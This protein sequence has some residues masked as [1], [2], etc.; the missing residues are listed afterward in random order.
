MGFILR[1]MKVG[2]E[3]TLWSQKEL[4]GMGFVAERALD[5]HA[6]TASFEIQFGHICPACKI[7]TII[8]SHLFQGNFSSSSRQ[9]LSTLLPMKGNSLHKIHKLFTENL[10]IIAQFG[11]RPL[12]I[13]RRINAR[14]SPY[15]RQTSLDMHVL[16]FVFSWFQM[17]AQ[18][19]IL[20]LR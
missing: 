6:G 16:C 12:K 5:L 19:H 15:H 9:F 1:A 4:I 13:V 3:T 17:F 8:R 2:M 11:C 7:F 10:F 14:H 20:T 18:M